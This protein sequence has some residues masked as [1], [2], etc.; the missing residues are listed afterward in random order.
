MS[1]S[2]LSRVG[3]TFSPSCL[4][5][6]QLQ[7]LPDPVATSEKGQERILAKG[8]PH[9]H[10]PAILIPVATLT[11]CGT[12]KPYPST[13]SRV[14]SFICAINAARDSSLAVATS[15]ATGRDDRCGSRNSSGG[16]RR[17]VIR[18]LWT[19][20]SRYPAASSRPRSS[21]ASA[22][23]NAASVPAAASLLIYRAKPSRSAIKYGDAPVHTLSAARPPG[24]STR[25]ISWR[26]SCR[27]GKNCNPC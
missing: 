13:Y 7:T 23:E 26:A 5:Y 2:G 15:P 18:M 27:S 10:H 4:V 25:R 11:S 20:T 17:N 22:S 12:A 24:T 3:L 6:P 8:H 14:F 16:G 21:A 19:D 1:A 9:N